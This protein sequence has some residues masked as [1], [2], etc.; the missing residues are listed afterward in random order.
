MIQYFT[1]PYQP[2]GGDID[3]QVATKVDLENSTGFDTSKLAAKFDLISLK[4]EVDKIDDNKLKTVPVDLS[5]LINVLNN[6]VIKKTV[7]DKLVAIVNNVDTSEFALKSNYDTDQSYLE[8][9]IS[10]TDK[11][12]PNTSRLVTKTN[13]NTKITEIESKTPS[14]GGLATNSALTAVESKIPDVSTLVK[15]KQIMTQKYQTFKRKLLII[16]M[17]NILTLQNLI[18]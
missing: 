13:N 16:I 14:I 4:A 11:E 7:Y 15:N 10:D 1:K 12:I 6:D 18:S 9:K 2:F 3:F 8:K 17:I 5:K